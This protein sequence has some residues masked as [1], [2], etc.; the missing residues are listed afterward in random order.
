MSGIQ[1]VGAVAMWFDAG[2]TAIR[3]VYGAVLVTLRASF[4]TDVVEGVVAVGVQG[5]YQEEAEVLL[6]QWL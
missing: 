5:G 4:G 3:R 2:R 1:E 6:Q